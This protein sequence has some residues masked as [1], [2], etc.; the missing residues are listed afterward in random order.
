MF[1]V[2]TD[3]CTSAPQYCKYFITSVTKGI[4]PSVKTA[5]LNA[6]GG[7]FS[8]GTYI[9]TLTNG[10]AVLSPYHDFASQVSATLQNELKQ[11]EAGIESGS[12]Q[13]PTKSP[14]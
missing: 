2:D 6:A 8:G 14:V 3:G 1:W 12:I 9:G 11:V 5:V 7:T 4:V 13:T 10:G